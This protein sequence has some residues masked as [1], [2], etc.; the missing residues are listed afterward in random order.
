MWTDSDTIQP[1]D[2]QVFMAGFHPSLK[3]ENFSQ[4]DPTSIGWIFHQVSGRKDKI[5]WW[6]VTTGGL[7]YEL[8][9]RE[10]ELLQAF[11]D[12]TTTEHGFEC[13]ASRHGHRPRNI[14]GI[15]LNLL[16]T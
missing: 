2:L 14:L 8:S 5:D 1:N 7:F 4:P 9:V 12:R 13:L 16:G 6:A 15:E 10:E 11:N 3:L